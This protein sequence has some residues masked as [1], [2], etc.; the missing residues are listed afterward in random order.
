M[1]SAAISLAIKSGGFCIFCFINHRFCVK[2]TFEERHNQS[3]ES[4]RDTFS[5][6]FFYAKKDLSGAV[7]TPNRSTVCS[8]ILL[9]ISFNPTPQP[10]YPDLQHH[11]PSYDFYA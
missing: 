8:S 10:Q 4:G 2:I 5:A 11:Q 6:R 1:V 7:R 3:A 9:L